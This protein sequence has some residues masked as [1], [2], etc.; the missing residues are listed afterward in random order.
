MDRVYT[1]ST[2]GKP[3]PISIKL[4]ETLQGIQAGDIEDK[5]NWVTLI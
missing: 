1:F 2:D 3:G 4:Y 5:R